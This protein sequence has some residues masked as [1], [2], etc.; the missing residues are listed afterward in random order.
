MRWKANETVQQVKELA[1]Q[2]PELDP[3]NSQKLFSGLYIACHGTDDHVLARAHT[4]RERE[5]GQ[6]ERQEEIVTNKILK[7]G[8][9]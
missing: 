1:L 4:P 9:K 8:G 6:I 5:K 2:K 7:I 3:Q